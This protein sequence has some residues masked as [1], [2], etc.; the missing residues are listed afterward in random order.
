[1]LIR[2][3][4]KLWDDMKEQ[5]SLGVSGPTYY[6][7]KK[8][9]DL[10]AAEVLEAIVRDL[11]RIPGFPSFQALWNAE[12]SAECPSSYGLPPAPERSRYIVKRRV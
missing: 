5:N 11:S 1:L 9:T 4:H 10:A 6:K 8:K 7:G 12:I 3:A 2:N